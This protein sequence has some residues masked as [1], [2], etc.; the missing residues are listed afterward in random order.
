MSC[1][2]IGLM[3][4]GPGLGLAQHFHQSPCTDCCPAAFRVQEGSAFMGSRRIV[5][6]ESEY[7]KRRLNRIISPDRNDAFQMGDK[8]PDARVRTYADV[9]R[10]A[11]LNRE[12]EN[13]LRNIAD[14][15]KAE[16]EAEAA[17]AE[18][19]L[20]PTKASGLAPAAPPP[21]AAP[22][23]TAPAAAAAA[24]AATAPGGKR[25]RWDSSVP[26]EA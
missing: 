11:Q 24:V 8:T 26:I 21:E 19:G 23:L 4:L 18:A 1:L 16:A 17:A 3:K 13:T 7:S 12:R 14:K 9:M 2:S 15:R 22:A 25:S 6:R 10:E 20:A 5:D